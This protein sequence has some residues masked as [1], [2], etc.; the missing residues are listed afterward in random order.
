MNNY[1]NPVDIE[2]EYLL[3][4]DNQKLSEIFRFYL[5][6]VVEPENDQVKQEAYDFLLLMEEAPELRKR[7]GEI[8][9]GIQS[10][11]EEKIEQLKS[12]LAEANR[13]K[14]GNQK[15]LKVLKQKHEQLNREID[16][17]KSEIAEMTEN[18]KITREQVKEMSNSE[19]KQR[20]K[21]ARELNALIAVKKKDYDNIINRWR[22][23]KEQFFNL[24]RLFKEK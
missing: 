18:L 19:K 16:E 24:C 15:K 2:F 3:N 21:K 22:L 12:T 8:R 10:K 23:K 4:C 13:V 17:K 5:K 14:E 7:V 20:I 9:G 11:L 1:I 6:A